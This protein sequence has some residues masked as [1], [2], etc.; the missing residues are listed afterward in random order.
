MCQ[1]A[2]NF[3]IS[4]FH[5]HAIGLQ[6]RCFLLCL[7]VFTGKMCF[8][9]GIFFPEFSRFSCHLN[10]DPTLAVVCFIQLELPCDSNICTYISTVV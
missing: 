3:N 8:S 1:V 6:L 4:Y 5:S 10:F 2:W 7:K 9:G